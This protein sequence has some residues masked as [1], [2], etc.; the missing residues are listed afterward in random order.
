M[1]LLREFHALIHTLAHS[2]S[3]YSSL[4]DTHFNV[5]IMITINTLQ[6]ISTYPM[7]F[8]FSHELVHQNT[9]SALESLPVKFWKPLQATSGIYNVKV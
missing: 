2:Q 4:P 3:H 7:I 6:P 5:I 1:R 8:L 9:P